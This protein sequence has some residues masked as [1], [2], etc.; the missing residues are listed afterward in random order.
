M[1]RKLAVGGVEIEVVARVTLS[2]WAAR[3]WFEVL[4]EAGSSC[5]GSE[6][7]IATSVWR[8][9]ERVDVCSVGGDADA[10]PAVVGSEVA[11]V[12]RVRKARGMA[13]FCGALGASGAFGSR[14]PRML[15]YG[16][17]V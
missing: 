17:L 3:G 5:A 12:Y 11:S 14:E 8:F 6:L 4:V 13:L 9:L 2:T 1:P 10:S 15:M 7:D 16:G